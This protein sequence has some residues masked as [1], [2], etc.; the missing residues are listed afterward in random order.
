MARWEITIADPNG[1]LAPV[2]L[3]VGGDTYSRSIVEEKTV[4]RF[5]IKNAAVL[6]GVRSS[7]RYIWSIANLTIPITDLRQLEKLIRLVMKG[8]RTHLLLTDEVEELSPETPTHQKRLIT[9]LDP[10]TPVTDGDGY[11]YGYGKFAVIPQ[12]TDQSP[13]RHLGY[14]GDREFKS[15]S[16][17]FLELPNIVVPE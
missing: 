11:I 4:N 15:V 17:Q 14:V 2:A 8:S 9:T 6:T 12:R 16:L 5:S 13:R 7:Y 1:T 10:V 3:K